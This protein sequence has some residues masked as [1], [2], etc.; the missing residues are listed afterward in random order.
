M[1]INFFQFQGEFVGAFGSTNLGDVSPNLNGPIC[2]NTGEACDYATS[3]CNGENKYCIAMGP[4]KDMF[5]SSQII[6]NRLANK[7]KVSS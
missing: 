7:A 2:V 4:G 5:E 1:L 6:A 3:T